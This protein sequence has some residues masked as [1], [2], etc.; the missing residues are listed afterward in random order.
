MQLSTARSVIEKETSVSI[1][2]EGYLK[3]ARFV[4]FR[5]PLV[6]RRPRILEIGF[7]SERFTFGSGLH[8]SRWIYRWCDPRSLGWEFIWCGFGGR[9]IKCN[10]TPTISYAQLKSAIGPL[11]RT[12]L[13][14]IMAMIG[15]TIASDCS[16]ACVK[17]CNSR[18]TCESSAIAPYTSVEDL[19]GSWVAR[20]KI[21]GDESEVMAEIKQRI[22]SLTNPFELQW[23]GNPPSRGIGN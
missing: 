17:C 5:N 3:S 21:E 13:R 19:S 6:N 11:C 18:A 23:R 20:I 22:N 10:F 2:S 7:N 14:Q 4:P 1:T 15:E 8:F 16:S 9:L 12:R